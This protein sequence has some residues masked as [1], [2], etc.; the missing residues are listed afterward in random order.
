MSHSRPSSVSAALPPLPLAPSLHTEPIPRIHSLVSSHPYPLSHFY[1]QDPISSRG[2]S[3]CGPLTGRAK[4][5]GRHHWDPESTSICTLSQSGL[6]TAIASED[7]PTFES[8]VSPRKALQGARPIVN[9]RTTAGAQHGNVR[10]SRLPGSFSKQNVPWS[11]RK[12]SLVISTT[13]SLDS[14]S[15]LC[16][17]LSVSST[18]C[19]AGHTDM[20][21]QLKEPGNAGPQSSLLPQHNDSPYDHMLHRYYPGEAPR[22]RTPPGPNSNTQ[23][24]S[25]QQNHHTHPSHHTPSHLR[26]SSGKSF[27]LVVCCY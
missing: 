2:P 6:A 7:Y 17:P 11:F 25:P 27:F 15:F 10:L 1:K 3:L 13:H 19:S 26:I 12:P 14:E 16:P 20:P 8:F 5:S 21:L 4:I 22:D 9:T 24:R 18:R 23:L